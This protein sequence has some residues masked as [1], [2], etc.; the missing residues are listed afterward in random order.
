MQKRVHLHTHVCLYYILTKE[1]K[2]T[3]THTH[4]T[5]Q[6]THNI[7]TFTQTHIVKSLISLLG[8]I[9]FIIGIFMYLLLNI[10]HEYINLVILGKIDIHTYIFRCTFSNVVH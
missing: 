4:P 3:H 6:H 9:R 2:Y 5:L 7:H 1:P 8:D 10:K